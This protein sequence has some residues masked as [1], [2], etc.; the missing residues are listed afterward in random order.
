[1]FVSLT[2]RRTKVI[3]DSHRAHSLARSL[4]S[5][6]MII[7]KVEMGLRYRH[8]LVTMIVLYGTGTLARLL[9][10]DIFLKQNK[11]RKQPFEKF[12]EIIFN[13]HSRTPSHER[14]DKST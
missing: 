8:I 11:K 1:M 5:L 6:P 2:C 13:I 9:C 12:T 14:I 4:A 7:K 3:T 10:I